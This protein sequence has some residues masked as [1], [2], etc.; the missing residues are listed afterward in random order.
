VRVFDRFACGGSTDGNSSGTGLGLAIVRA[1]A[2]AH[3]GTVA[4]VETSSKGA[5]FRPV[6]PTAIIRRKSGGRFEGHHA[7]ADEVTRIL[8]AEDE[9]RIASF[10]E[11]GCRP[12]V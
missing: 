6:L 10:I 8:I 3:G 2:Q 4:F 11:R 7:G 1:I 12:A 5:E 9:A